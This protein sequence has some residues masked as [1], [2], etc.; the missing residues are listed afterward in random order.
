MCLLITSLLTEIGLNLPCV[1]LNNYLFSSEVLMM[2]AQIFLPSTLVSLKT[3]T[4]EYGSMTVYCK[5][6]VQCV[7]LCPFAFYSVALSS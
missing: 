7:Y 6:S 5:S 3:C 4:V 1:A 2:L